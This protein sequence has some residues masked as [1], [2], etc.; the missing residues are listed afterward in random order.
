[1]SALAITVVLLVLAFVAIVVS[2]GQRQPVEVL[3]AAPAPA[4]EGDRS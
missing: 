3:P 1:M 4:A 2:G